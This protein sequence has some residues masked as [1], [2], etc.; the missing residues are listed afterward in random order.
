MEQDQSRKLLDP[1]P[2]GPTLGTSR[3]EICWPRKTGR[4]L[5]ALPPAPA[6]DEIVEAIP[7]RYNKESELKAEIKPGQNH[8]NFELKSK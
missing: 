4:K 1:C 3:V 7:E 2:Q 6:V 5:P 8:L